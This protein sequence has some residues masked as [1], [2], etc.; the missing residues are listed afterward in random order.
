MCN[1]GGGVTFER[2]NNVGENIRLHR[3][4]AGYTIK[5][6][7]EK[8]GERHGL[9]IKP[10]AVR[11]YEKGE[12]EIPAIILRAIAEITKTD[13]RAFFDRADK[14]VLLDGDVRNAR[15]LEAYSLINDK[16]AKDKLL[17]MARMFSRNIKA[18]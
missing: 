6:F 3:I 8:I 12:E 9:A 14:S 11:N 16:A 7:C 2:N 10:G 5:A 18:A 4:K 17:H 15:L 1:S 13:I